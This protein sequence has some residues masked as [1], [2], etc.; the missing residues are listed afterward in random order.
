M[1]GIRWSTTAKHHMSLRRTP[2]SATLRPRRLPSFTSPT[3][4]AAIPPSW[5]RLECT[6]TGVA[7]LRT[8]LPRRAPRSRMGI[9]CWYPCLNSV[10]AWTGRATTVTTPTAPTVCSSRRAKPTIRMRETRLETY[11]RHQS[12][13]FHVFLAVGVWMDPRCWC[14]ATA[15]SI[16][17]APCARALHFPLVDLHASTLYR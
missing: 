16:P 13:P 5:I 6:S 7:G 14:R 15:R 2:L 3:T 9:M 12:A 17:S 4:T 8:G 10:A 1:P 11:S